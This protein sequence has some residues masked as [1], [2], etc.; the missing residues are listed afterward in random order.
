MTSKE[1]QELCHFP[2]LLDELLNEKFP[3]INASSAYS[4]YDDSFVT[5]F[6]AEGKLKAEVNTFIAGFMAGNQELS[7]RM[8]KLTK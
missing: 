8:L 3:G 4:F 1:R 5:N 6:E 7:S 2:R